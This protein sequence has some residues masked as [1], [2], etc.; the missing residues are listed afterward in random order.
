MWTGGFDLDSGKTVGEKGDQL[1]VTS[2]GKNP[3]KAQEKGRIVRGIKRTGDRI[4][5]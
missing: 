5:A 1:K 4:P 2:K 3:D